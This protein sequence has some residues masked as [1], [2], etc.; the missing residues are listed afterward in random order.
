MILQILCQNEGC[1]QDGSPHRWRQCSR[2][3]RARCRWCPGWSSTGAPSAPQ[4]S[5]RCQN[6]RRT[7]RRWC[8]AGRAQTPAPRPS[9]RSGSPPMGP[10]SRSLILIQK[11][12]SF[13]N[14]HI[15]WAEFPGGGNFGVTLVA[16]ASSTSEVD[17]YWTE[18]RQENTF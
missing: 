16:R 11:W 10:S 2:A 8:S 14:V 3:L 7:A 12:R 15:I 6:P 4:K 9:Q 17:W 13:N 5:P 18:D 1:F